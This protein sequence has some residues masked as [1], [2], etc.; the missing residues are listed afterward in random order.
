MNRFDI[1]ITYR[2][3]G[4]LAH[5]FY[6]HFGVDASGAFHAARKQFDKEKPDAVIE[7]YAVVGFGKNSKG[8]TT[9]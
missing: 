1:K 4:T 2:R 7:D 5:Y 3:D 9:P 6:R 8:K